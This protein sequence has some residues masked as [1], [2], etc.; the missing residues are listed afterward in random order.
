MS[1][2]FRTVKVQY[3]DAEGHI[4]L[5]ET[6]ASQRLHKVEDEVIVNGVPQVVQSVTLVVTL[7]PK[8]E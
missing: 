8:E 6:R 5:E 3:Q 2:H 1:P 4:L 7:I